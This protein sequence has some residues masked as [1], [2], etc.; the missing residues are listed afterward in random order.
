MT[1]LSTLFLSHSLFTPLEIIMKRRF[2][3]GANERWRKQLSEAE[4]KKTKP[5]ISYLKPLEKKP[6]QTDSAIEIENS[7]TVTENISEYTS[8]LQHED[9]NREVLRYSKEFVCD[10]ETFQQQEDGLSQQEI[11]GYCR[12]GYE[13]HFEFWT[14]TVLLKCI[15]SLIWVTLKFQVL[16][17]KMPQI[18]FPYSTGHKHPSKRWEL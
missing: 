12:F 4:A 5:R 10:Q 2:E 6:Y 17:H 16:F 11:R 9:S 18:S 14:G 3:S 15:C 1:T 13:W 7:M 8:L